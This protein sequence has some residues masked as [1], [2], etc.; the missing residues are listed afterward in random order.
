MVCPF[1]KKDQLRT[2]MRK[3]EVSSSKWTRVL[4]KP[5]KQTWIIHKDPFTYFA[6]MFIEFKRQKFNQK[7]II[8][9]DLLITSFQICGVWLRRTHTKYALAA[10]Y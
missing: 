5:K 8:Y 1:Y 6:P 10:A 9:F 7:E 2:R 3:A 4:A